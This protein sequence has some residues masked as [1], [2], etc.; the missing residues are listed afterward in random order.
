[1]A[2]PGDDAT[3]DDAIISSVHSRWRKVAL[4]VAKTEAELERSGIV[5]PLEAIGAR[6]TA[7]VQSGR[8][9]GAGNLC[10]WRHSEVRLPPD[11]Q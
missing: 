3:I 9:E 1:M 6:V 7:L 4:I 11:A 10:R 2:T 5:V 8:L